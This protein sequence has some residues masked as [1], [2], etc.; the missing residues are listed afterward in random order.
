MRD[1]RAEALAQHPRPLLDQGRRR[2]T[3]AWCRA[4]TTAEPLVLAVY[5]EVLRAGGLPIVQMAPEEAAA[6]FYRLG[7]DEQLDW[8][9]PTT[10]WTA[11]NADV[12]IVVMADANSR[13]L[14]GVDPKKQARAQKA[15][16]SR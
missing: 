6:A 1:H 3:C 8:I 14:S 16:A 10:E 11:E 15:A 7:S 5:E 4:P 2:A 13:A 12:R 9:P